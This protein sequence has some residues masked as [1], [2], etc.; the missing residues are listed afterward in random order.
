VKKILLGVI[1]FLGAVCL[2][3]SE[4]L[5]GQLVIIKDMVNIRQQPNTES[6]ILARLNHGHVIKELQK[7]GRWFE[8]ELPDEGNMQGWVWGGLVAPHESDEVEKPQVMAEMAGVDLTAAELTTVFELLEPAVRE[9]LLSRPDLLERVIREE[10]LRKAI[11]KEALASGFDKD[12]MIAKFMER[13]RWQSLADHFLNRQARFQDDY[14][15]DREVESYYNGHISEFMRPE[16]LHL[17][18]IFFA[19][20][21]NL[22]RE[23]LQERERRVREIVELAGKDG[24]DFSELA[25]EFSEHK[26]TAERGGDV[27]WIAEKSLLPE[28]REVMVKLKVGDVSAP[29]RSSLGWHIFKLIDR[30]EER[31]KSLTAASEQI[32]QTLRRSK[33]EENRRDYIKK[34]IEKQPISIDKEVYDGS[35]LRE[36][37]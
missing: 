10:L 32:R 3:A 9:N 23:Q 28:V 19:A 8:I 6:R 7:Q 11:I 24:A 35:L 1:V 22:D 29:I 27:G 5:A 30:Q 34:L 21:S 31:T 18:Q 13:A 2:M 20:G 15:A 33:S 17:G 36:M 14:P 25:R 4:G 12:P 26:A 16:R 37:D